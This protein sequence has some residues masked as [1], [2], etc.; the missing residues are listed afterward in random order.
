MPKA[1][2]PSYYHRYRNWVR[3]RRHD[4][5][6][7]FLPPDPVHV[8]AEVEVFELL[9]QGKRTC[10]YRAQLNGQRV[11]LKVYRAAVMRRY[12]WRFDV[13]L[14]QFEHDRNRAFWDNPSLR[15]F[16]VEPL[17]LYGVDDGYSPAFVQAWAEGVSLSEYASEHG[18]VST[19]ILAAGQRLVRCAHAAG[20]Y[21]LDLNVGNIKLRE[22]PA[23]PMPVIYDFNLLPQHLYAP[24]PARW[25]SLRLGRRHWGHRDFAALESWAN[26]GLFAHALHL[27]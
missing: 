24:N 6:G 26:H 7:R 25:L 17:R 21:D 5:Q 27:G 13:H 8:P 1:S 4:R 18:Y 12:R 9:G 2:A 19:D 16:T 23:G 22:T 14:A 10:T 3:S 11:V 20:L 15:D